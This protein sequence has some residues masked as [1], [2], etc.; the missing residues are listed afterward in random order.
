ML[1]ARERRVLAYYRHGNPVRGQDRTV[2]RRLSSIG[3]V[4]LGYRITPEGPE[5]TAQTTDRGAHQVGGFHGLLSRVPG[6][7]GKLL[8]GGSV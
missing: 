4:R 7:V 5:S 2:L 6:F 1:T 3:M 8:V